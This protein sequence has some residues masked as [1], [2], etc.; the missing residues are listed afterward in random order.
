MEG[1]YRD[2]LY[3]GDLAAAMP[4]MMCRMVRFGK[5]GWY[6]RHKVGSFSVSRGF[7]IVICPLNGFREAMID[8]GHS[9]TNKPKSFK[10]G[11][12]V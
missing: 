7:I 5:D 9:L 11:R 3:G 6:E 12:T 8:F 10:K 1:L 2:T 4:E